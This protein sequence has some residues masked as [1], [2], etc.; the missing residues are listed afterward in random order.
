MKAGRWLDAG[1]TGLVALGVAFLFYLGLYDRALGWDEI[2][3]TRATEWVRQG[4]VP[5]RD[6]FEHHS[7]LMWFLMAPWRGLWDGPGADVVIG[8]RVGLAPLWIGAL[9]A[10]ARLMTE[11]GLSPF[12]RRASIATLLFTPAFSFSAVEFRIDGVSTPLV[13]AALCVGLSKSRWGSFLSGL[14]LAQAVMANLRCAPVA[15]V[16]PL[17]LGWRAKAELQSRNDPRTDDVEGRRSVTFGA[18]VASHVVAGGLFGALVWVVYFLVTGSLLA[19]YQQNIVELAAVARANPYAFELA[20][21]AALP[22][23]WGDLPG[24]MIVFGGTIGAV[25]HAARAP[26]RELRVISAVG[27]ASALSLVP[28]QPVYSYHVGLTLVLWVPV[29]ATVYDRFAGA[30]RWALVTGLFGSFAWNVSRASSHST[31]PSLEYQDQVMREV[32]AKTSADQRILDAVGFALRR[33]PAYERW[34]VPAGIQYLSATGAISEYGPSR[35]EANPPA[36]VITG[37]RF[38]SWV[39]SSPALGEYVSGHFL[40]TLPNLWLPGLSARL[41][42]D[43]PTARWVVPKS[44]EYRWICAP[45]LASHPHF[46]SPFER[47]VPARAPR[48]IP[49]IDSTVTASCATEL[50]LDSRATQPSP[51]LRLEKGQVL[52]ARSKTPVGVFLIPEGTGPVFQPAPRGAWLDGWSGVGYYEYAR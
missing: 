31:R 47:S 24:V 27:L 41:A 30:A 26:S 6:F 7:P 37:M 42:P 28:L 14:I 13:L 4:R 33:P 3:Y 39:R 45:E 22:V 10:W 2:E 25:F 29:L 32:D 40:P 16:A 35:A 48:S 15:L 5:F 21:I 8:M 36:A 52:E 12:A 11:L 43:R 51:T 19:A 17:A 34:F 44:S 20:S 23:V 9:V 18:R 50:W 1:A 46:S 49:S 38:R